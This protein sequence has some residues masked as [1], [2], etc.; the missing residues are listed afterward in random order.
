[1]FQWNV[2]SIFASFIRASLTVSSWL[3]T[4]NHGNERVQVFLSQPHHN[5]GTGP[6]L[7]QAQVIKRE[8]RAKVKSGLDC[9]HSRDSNRGALCDS[10]NRKDL[11]RFFLEKCWWCP[12]ISN[13]LLRCSLDHHHNKNLV[14]NHIWILKLLSKG[15]WVIRYLLYLQIPPDKLYTNHKREKW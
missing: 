4:S 6:F 15:S 3:T 9:L 11:T 7:T 2:L 12:L 8:S 1:M 10:S 13:T 14:K 5:K